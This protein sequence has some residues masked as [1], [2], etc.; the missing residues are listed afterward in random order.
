MISLQNINAKTSDVREEICMKLVEKLNEHPDISSAGLVAYYAYAMQMKFFSYLIAVTPS[1]DSIFKQENAQYSEWTENL[2][3]IL[4]D[5]EAPLV[6]SFAKAKYY[7]DQLF[8]NITERGVLEYTYHKKAL[9]TSRQ[10]QEH[11]G[12]SRSTISRYVNSG[13]EMVSGV[14]HHCYPLHNVFYW[15]D[16]VWASRI[17]VLYQSYRLRNRTKTDLIDEIKAEIKQFEEK[18]G[19]TFEDV[20]KDVTDPYELD[21]PDDY[22]DWRDALEELKKFYE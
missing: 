1:K 21:E 7:L 2:N 5:K 6:E 4:A 18:Y 16:G 15:S 10:L 14:G 11:L 20:F 17:Q 13:M 12:V 19:G 9:I 8:F 22:F 3:I